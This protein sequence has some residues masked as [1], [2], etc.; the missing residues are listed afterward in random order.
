MLGAIKFLIDTPPS[1][2]NLVS[3]VLEQHTAAQDQASKEESSVDSQVGDEVDTGPEATNKDDGRSNVV[4]K[5][6]GPLAEDVANVDKSDSTFQEFY[7][8]AGVVIAKYDVPKSVDRVAD[9]DDKQA[10]SPILIDTIKLFELADVVTYEHWG[11][12]KIVQCKFGLLSYFYRY[13]SSE[14]LLEDWSTTGHLV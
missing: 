8:S 1:A 2:S 12:K 13:T 6:E 9:A 14:K 11:S 3:T 5:N 4:E 10:C 7:T